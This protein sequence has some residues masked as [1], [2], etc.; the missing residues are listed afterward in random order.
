[1]SV[2]AKKRRVTSNAVAHAFAAAKEGP[3]LD[4]KERA[5]LREAMADPKWIRMSRGEAFERLVCDDDE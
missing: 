2:P 4:E 3:P 5:T 1:M